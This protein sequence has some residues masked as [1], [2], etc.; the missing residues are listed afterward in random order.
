MKQVVHNRII[1][2]K[3]EVYKSTAARMKADRMLEKIV[4]MLLM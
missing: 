2:N 4:V 3:E 1:E